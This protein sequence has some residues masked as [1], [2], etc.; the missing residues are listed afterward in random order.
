MLVRMFEIPKEHWKFVLFHWKHVTMSLATIWELE[1][2][3][4]LSYVY[5]GVRAALQAVVVSMFS[6]KKHVRA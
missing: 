6:M 2:R 3:V 1:Q 5:Q 4:D